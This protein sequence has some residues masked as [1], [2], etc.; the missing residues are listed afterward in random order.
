MRLRGKK[1][2]ARQSEEKPRNDEFGGEKK[3]KSG[4]VR[5]GGRER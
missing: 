1:G 2:R 5:V 4:Y 3:I